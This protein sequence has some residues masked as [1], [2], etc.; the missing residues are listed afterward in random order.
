MKA[1]LKPAVVAL[2]FS[3]VLAGAG[4]EEILSPDFS[5]SADIRAD[6]FDTRFA[7]EI[8]AV[9]RL[10]DE[11][12]TGVSG[13]TFGVSTRKVPK[14]GLC[15]ITVRP[16]VQ[17]G[18]EGTWILFRRLS[19]GLPDSIRIYPVKD[20]SVYITVRPEGNDP[21][22][23]KSLLDLTIYGG[24]ARRSVPVGTAFTR[25]YT[26][27]VAD[28]VAATR[29]VMPWRLLA[30][31][32]DDF[33]AIKAAI[34]AIREGLPG[35]VYLDDGCFNENGD[36][37]LIKTGEKQDTSAIWAALGPEQKA[38]GIVGGVNCSG[39]AK[40][41]VDGIIRPRAGTGLKIDP[42]K[43]TTVSAASFFN[44]PYRETRD[45]YFGLD[46]TRN[47]ASAV[48]SLDARKTVK[49]DASGVDVVSEPFAGFMGYTLDV[50]Y[51]M[52]ELVP[53]LYWLAAT[54]PGHF[55]LGAV[56]SMMGTPSLRQYHH[57][58]VFFPYFDENAQFRVTVFESA[59]ESTIADFTKTYPESYIH[60]V[61]VR[62]PEE[63]FFQP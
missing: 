23:G 22:K 12:V 47:L 7:G 24:L 5:D 30:P 32:L 33:D 2:F 29:A 60:L 36:A 20:A 21:D 15:A 50:G 17:S 35:L 26:M 58:A 11:E 57:V 3:I 1:F 6:L 14:A 40:W 44:E 13:E 37:V 51:R 19:D 41:V 34:A 28:L 9:L 18:A 61:R 54:E 43:T 39:F 8:S 42:L 53:M 52:Q 55:Y 10:S 48:V 27:S 46:W 31:R 63:G 38:S 25:L 56:S 49:P 62:V 45:L 16:K 4:A 59:R